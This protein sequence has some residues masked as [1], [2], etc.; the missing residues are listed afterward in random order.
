[1]PTLAAFE[2]ISNIY[3]NIVS[4]DGNVIK[5]LIVLFIFAYLWVQYKFHKATMNKISVIDTSVS[6][7][8][9]IIHDVK[10]DQ[11]HMEEKITEIKEKIHEDKLSRIQFRESLLTK[12]EDVTEKVNELTDDFKRYKILLDHKQAM[13]ATTQVEKY[14]TVEI[15]FAHDI[16]DKFESYLL[17]LLN[18]II[19]HGTDVTKEML[20]NKF[21]EIFAKETAMQFDFYTENGYDGMIITIIRNVNQNVMVVVKK[22]IDDLMNTF[23]DRYK[24]NGSLGE[25]IKAKKESWLYKWERQFREQFQHEVQKVLNF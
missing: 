6:S 3:N 21:S 17:G 25:I 22:S 11:E 13:L 24:W 2:A 9:L 14:I 23:I 12:Q 10:H 19:M 7:L 8:G 18:D 5:P 20:V 16:I 1:M 4:G 15:Q